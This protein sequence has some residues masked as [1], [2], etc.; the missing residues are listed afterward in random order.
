MKYLI[1]FIGGVVFTLGVFLFMQRQE[2]QQPEVPMATASSEVETADQTEGTSVPP[3]FFQFYTQFH[4][5]STFQLAHIRFPL[6]GI[7]ANV[8]SLTLTAGNFRWTADQWILHKPF[9]SMEGQFLRYFDAF[10]SDMVVERIQDSSGSYGMQRR[11][12]RFD[13]GWQ[14]IFYAAMNQL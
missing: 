4:E 12:A 9:D 7:P 11:F 6:Q 5:D 1:G 10:G 2:G 3:D 8:D 13:D 14:L